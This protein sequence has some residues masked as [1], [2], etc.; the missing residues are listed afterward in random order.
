MRSRSIYIIIS[1]RPTTGGDA[2]DPLKIPAVRL[3][4]SA[5][6]TD[7]PAHGGDTNIGTVGS[8]RDFVASDCLLWQLSG[9][10]VGKFD[11]AEHCNRR[12]SWIFTNRERRSFQQQRCGGLGRLVANDVV[13]QRKPTYGYDLGDADRAA[14]HSLG[15]RV[16]PHERERE[17]NPRFGGNR[18]D[19]RKPVWCPGLK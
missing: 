8:V 9:D 5:N 4:P 12:R 11:L 2:D 6:S 10:A 13:C 17:R 7:V 18:D 16:Q 19:E 3:G 14:G 15:L 1:I